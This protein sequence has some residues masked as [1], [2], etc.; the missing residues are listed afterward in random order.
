M[1]KGIFLM[2]AVFIM[3]TFAGCAPHQVRGGLTGGAMGGIAGAVLDHRN[4]WRGGVIGASL[5]ALAGTAISDAAVYGGGGYYTPR[6]ASYPRYSV[7]R[8]Y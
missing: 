1:S 4:P 8:G 2:A 7:P 6:S 5:G 3:T